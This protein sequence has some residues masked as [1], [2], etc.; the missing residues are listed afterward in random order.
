MGTSEKEKITP[1]E[2]ARLA[3]DAVCFAVLRILNREREKWTVADRKFMVSLIP[4]LRMRLRAHE[5]GIAECVME[6]HV[7]ERERAGS[8]A[9]HEAPE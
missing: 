8:S 3:G 7:L 4:L 2:I 1:I 6:L 5:S 9:D